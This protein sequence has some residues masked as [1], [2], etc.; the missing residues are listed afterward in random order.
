MICLHFVGIKLLLLCSYVYSFQKFLQRDSRGSQK[1]EPSLVIS[2][3]TIT[4]GGYQR[5]SIDENEVITFQG[6]KYSYIVELLKGLK[7]V[8]DCTTFADVGA[9]TGLVSF[10]A[11]SNMVGFQHA[12]L[13]DHDIPCISIASAI[14]A[15]INANV[16]AKRFDFGDPIP[17]VDVLFC[18]AIIHWVFCLTADFQGNFDAIMQYLS[19][20]TNKYLVIEWVDK[21]DG[22]IRRFDHIGKCG[23]SERVAYYN[24]ENFLKSLHRIGN[25]Q[26]S[27]S[28]GQRTIY[29]VKVNR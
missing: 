4:V 17:T 1:E 22:A 7:R 15:A 27:R 12:L 23:N 20:S 21:E 26:H 16:T 13:L 14:S 8:D 18:G 29:T 11:S 19:R 2:N 28:F 5:F 3:G 24:R 9:N 10:L 6:N 25:V